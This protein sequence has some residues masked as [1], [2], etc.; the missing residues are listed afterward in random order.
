M[1]VLGGYIQLKRKMSSNDLNAGPREKFQEL[2]TEFNV[3]GKVKEFLKEAGAI[4][5]WPSPQKGIVTF[6][7]RG[8]LK[9]RVTPPHY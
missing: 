1:V 4:T 3:E 5:R 8:K 9:G 6:A 7:S 2:L